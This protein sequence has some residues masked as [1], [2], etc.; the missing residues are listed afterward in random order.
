MSLSLGSYLPLNP[1]TPGLHSPSSFFFLL[2]VSV[3]VSSGVLS[4]IIGK[5][6]RVGGYEILGIKVYD[7]DDLAKDSR[8]IRLVDIFLSKWWSFHFH[9]YVLNPCCNTLLMT[10]ETPQSSKSLANVELNLL[11]A[12]MEADRQKGNSKILFL[13]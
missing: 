9:F 4:V 13:R 3:K 6:I 5:S 2:S 7:Q 12:S 8:L 11:L 1:I 10:F